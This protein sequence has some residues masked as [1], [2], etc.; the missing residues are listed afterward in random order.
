MKKL[1]IKTITCHDVYNYGASLQAYALMQYLT[2]QGHIVE[3]IDYKPPHLSKRYNFWMIPE[4]WKKN[5]VLK[6][7]YLLNKIP[8][9]L[10]YWGGGGR[11]RAFDKF[12]KKY[13]FLTNTK[14]RSNK[15]LI[16][17]P[18]NADIYIAGSDQIWNT[19]S[20]NGKDPSFYLNF[21]PEDAI[22]ASYAA[23]FSISEIQEEYRAFVFNMLQHLDYISVR[24]RTGLRILENLG[25][26]NAKLVLDPVF[27]LEKNYWDKIASY[28]SDEKYILVYD[29]ENNPRIRDFAI[30]I[31]KTK[32]IKIYIIKD[33]F[34]S[35]YADVYI[36]SAGPLEFLQL[37]KNCEV[38]LSNS[39][40]G[41]AFSIIYEKEFYVF[42]RMNAPV[43]SRMAD[44]L[45]ELNMENRLIIDKNGTLD[46]SKINYGKA[47]QIL[48]SLI[49]D[50][51][52]YLDKILIEYT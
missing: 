27:L 2:L 15:D 51:K 32:G 31:A 3:I 16:Q 47:N 39:F 43:N 38:L 44:L 22:K 25:I 23:S 37:I 30:K 20:E 36:D 21:A 19:Q 26:N 6:I 41:T 11:K 8:S 4:K 49:C 7:M 48:N 40:H 35:Q 34:I 10:V 50:S 29:F 28:Q 33:Y 45:K 24:E 1:N 52:N 18:P 42:N 5:I 46:Q 17:N 12:T 13:L 9:I 14:Y